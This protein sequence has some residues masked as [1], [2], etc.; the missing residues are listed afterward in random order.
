M[1]TV[2]VSSVPI[3]GYCASFLEPVRG[4]F[5]ANFR[6]YGDL[7]GAVAITIDGELAVELSGGYAD[8]ARTR[9]WELLDEPDG[10][11]GAPDPTRPTLAP[12]RRGGPGASP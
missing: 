1:T 6:D 5:E 7:G 8:A 11:P 10:G 4:L 2:P 3:E 9:P 12:H